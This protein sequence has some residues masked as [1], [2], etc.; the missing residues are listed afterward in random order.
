MIDGLPRSATVRALQ[1]CV[2]TFVARDTYYRFTKTH[3]EIHQVLVALLAS[4]LR[5]A[6]DA[7]ATYSFLSSKARVARALLEFARHMGSKAIKGR[8]VMDYKISQSDLAAFAGVARE[9]VSRA[10]SEWQ[11]RKLINRSASYYCIND[12]TKLEAE[13]TKTGAK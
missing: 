11:R 12:I 6:N 13:A 9:H 7:M 10:M 2:L 8:V 5:A 3:P 4:R 1:E